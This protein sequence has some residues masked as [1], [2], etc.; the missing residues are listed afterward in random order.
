[1][2]IMHFDKGIGR[3][4]PPNPL[5]LAVVQ[6]DGMK[7]LDQTMWPN[8]GS[9]VDDFFYGGGVSEF[10]EGTFATAKWNDGSAS[11]LHIYDIA[12]ATPDMQFKV[13]NGPIVV[14]PNGGMGGMGGMSLGG[15]GGA[16]GV[17]GDAGSAGMV[18]ASGATLAG[19]GGVAGGGV[20]GMA[21]S[22][23]V[24]GGSSGLMSA[25]ASSASPSAVEGSCACR[26]AGR[27]TGSGWSAAMLG[28]LLLRRRRG[29]RLVR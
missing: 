18:G 23:L 26:A 12:P 21:G 24:E 8:P 7:E 4:D 5:S 14:D 10:S 28:V 3:N 11:K 15:G 1:L 17:S 19:S 20:P 16:G 27:D 22:S 2:L 25:G 9:D 6:A 29:R 13:G